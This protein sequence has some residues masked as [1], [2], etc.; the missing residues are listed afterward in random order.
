MDDGRPRSARPFRF[1]RRRL[2]S[3]FLR[4]ADGPPPPVVLHLGTL[5]TSGH[6][7]RPQVDGCLGPAMP[8]G[9]ETCLQR[10]AAC[11]AEPCARMPP[12][13]NGSERTRA[14]SP[15]SDSCLRCLVSLLNSL[16]ATV[17]CGLMAGSGALVFDRRRSGACFSRA[18][19]GVVRGRRARSG[20]VPDCSKEHLYAGRSRDDRSPR[21]S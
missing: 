8:R 20:R 4:S 6:V 3:A 11:V 15:N 5:Q 2:S 21:A 18:G 1:D 7:S 9:S 14:R 10:G 16:P 12:L 13:A 19:H 17:G